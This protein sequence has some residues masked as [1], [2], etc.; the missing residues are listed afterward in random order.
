MLGDAK[1]RFLELEGEIFAQVGTALCARTL[2]SALPAEHIAKI[3]QVAEDVV[4]I[5]EH[6]GVES[7]IAARAAG[8]SGVSEAVVAGALLGVGEN[9]VGFAAL[10]E[11]LLGRGILGIAVGMVLQCELAVGA[12][13]LLVVGGTLT[14]STS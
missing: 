2:A 13:D 4:E 1:H 3:E 9:R 7:A 6:R 8:N 12:L 11:A 14:P 5:V 10:L